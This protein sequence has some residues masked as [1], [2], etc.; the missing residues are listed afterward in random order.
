M[1][2]KLKCK[3]GGI[4]IYFAQACGEEKKSERERE[5]NCLFVCGKCIYIIFKSE[6]VQN[7]IFSPKDN[8]K[9]QFFLENRGK[10][11]TVPSCAILHFTVATTLTLSIEEKLKLKIIIVFQLI[12]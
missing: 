12:F 2:D 8:K 3:R 6:G 1:K 10:F 9:N 7:F 5:Q 11:L 4:H